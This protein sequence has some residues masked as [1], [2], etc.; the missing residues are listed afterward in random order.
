LILLTTVIPLSTSYLL[1]CKGNYDCEPYLVCA[2]MFGVDQCTISLFS[3]RVKVVSTEYTHTQDS[4]DTVDIGYGGMTTGEEKQIDNSGKGTFPEKKL[5]MI[6]P[7]TIEKAKKKENEEKKVNM[8]DN[9]VEE[10]KEHK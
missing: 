4:S 2:R 7:I 6:G 9:E 10:K 3:P 1:P 8:V 5:V